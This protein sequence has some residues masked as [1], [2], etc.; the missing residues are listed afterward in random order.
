MKSERMG[1]FGALGVVTTVDVASDETLLM[2]SAIYI[3]D[4]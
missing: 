3:S 4:F 1:A 2:G